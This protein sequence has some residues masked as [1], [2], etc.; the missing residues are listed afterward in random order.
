MTIVIR[1]KSER[2]DVRASIHLQIATQALHRIVQC[3]A[4]KLSHRQSRH[5]LP[6]RLLH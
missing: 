4:S 2:I 5:N 1:S 3:Y 6:H